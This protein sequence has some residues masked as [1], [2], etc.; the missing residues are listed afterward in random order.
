MANIIAAWDSSPGQ[1]IGFAIETLRLEQECYLHF[2]VLEE[3]F[4]EATPNF[5]PTKRLRMGF[6]IYDEWVWIAG[7]QEVLK[8]LGQGPGALLRAYEGQ[9]LIL[10]GNRTS[11]DS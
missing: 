3:V 6:T 9:H 4:K 1:Y 2:L 8:L 11:L 5:S 7:L 10:Q